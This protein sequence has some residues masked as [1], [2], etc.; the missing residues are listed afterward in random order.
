[1]DHKHAIA[2]SGRSNGDEGSTSSYSVRALSVRVIRD[3]SPEAE[4][5]EGETCQWWNTS[6]LAERGLFS[7]PHSP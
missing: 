6:F 2:D 7:H 1:M 4:L 3:D 5:T